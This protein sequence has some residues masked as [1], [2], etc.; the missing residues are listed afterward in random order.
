VLED[1]NAGYVVLTS[2]VLFATVAYFVP[3]MN[4]GWF[5]AFNAA[6]T[7]FLLAT[8]AMTAALTA[9]LDAIPLYERARPIL[10]ALPETR[11]TH[12]APVELKGAIELSRVNFRYGADG[13]AVLDDLSLSIAAGEF[14]AFVGP[15]GSGKST[16]FRLLLGFERP[17]SGAI[18]YDDRDLA[19]LDVTGVRVQLGVVLQNG[20]LMP[21]DIYS[22]IVGASGASV[23]EAWDAARLAGLEEEIQAMP[24]GMH[25]LI[26]E[27]AS[28]L[29]GG[30]KQRLMIAR[31]VARKP[32]ILLFDE[33]TSALDNRAQAAVADSLERLGATRIVIAH[34]LSTVL[35]ADRIFVIDAGRVV[36]S[37][38]Y[39]E[40]MAR[41][42][43]FAELARRQIV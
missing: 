35:D 2:M 33:A 24:M 30:Q 1:F 41:D 20:R 9:S 7:Q 36:E 43:R 32:R 11:E 42:G 21:G 37:G 12:G 5:I 29:S 14:V 3:E 17:D 39:T 10:D 27:G 16:L 26:G 8:L 40:L 13:P 25:T 18:Y 34:R 4:A 19:G 15:S 6:F 28:M 31:A 22:N 38:N 23:E